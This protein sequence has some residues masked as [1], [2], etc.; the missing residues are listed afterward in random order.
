[1]RKLLLADARRTSKLIA[2]TNIQS[3]K[4]SKAMVA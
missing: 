4:V 3:T 1:L 2:G